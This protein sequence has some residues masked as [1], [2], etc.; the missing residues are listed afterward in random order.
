MRKAQNGRRLNAPADQTA[1]SVDA[2]TSSNRPLPAHPPATTPSMHPL[3]HRE[4]PFLT[5]FHQPH[6]LL[7]ASSQGNIDYRRR[8][9]RI[10]GT[11]TAQ[12][13]CVAHLV[14]FCKNILFYPFYLFTSSNDFIFL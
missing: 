10:K 5:P 9:A 14:N 12:H 2:P 3:H 4:T 6:P 11:T 1:R 7:E 8:R 13:S